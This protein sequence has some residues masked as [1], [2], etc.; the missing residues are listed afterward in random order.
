MKK[1]SRA[2]RSSPTS[3]VEVALAGVLVEADAEEL[4][5]DHTACGGVHIFREMKS[6][7][8]ALSQPENF[9]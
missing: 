5:M 2:F 8:D 3:I 1:F 9:S 7:L 6:L 4:E